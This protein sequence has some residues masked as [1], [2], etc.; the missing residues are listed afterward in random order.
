MKN[1]LSTIVFDMVVDI[2][3]ASLVFRVAGCRA[4]KLMTSVRYGSVGDIQAN[5][6]RA[7]KS[8]LLGRDG[9]GAS[10]LMH[11]AQRGDTHVFCAVLEFLS[12]RLSSGEVTRDAN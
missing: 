4:A 11:A 3:Q 1:I 7:D 8:Q 10:L 9:E 5:L 2:K 6:M 12:K